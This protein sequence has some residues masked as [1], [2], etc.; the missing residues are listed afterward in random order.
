[1]KENTSV[2]LK[3]AIVRNAGIIANSLTSDQQR[4][5][6]EAEIAIDTAKQTV[7]VKQAQSC[8]IL[9]SVIRQHSN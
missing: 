7:H 3:R 6:I 5:I 4:E 8:K 1:M 2:L 9:Q